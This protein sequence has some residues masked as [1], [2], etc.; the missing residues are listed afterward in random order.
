MD[1]YYAVWPVQT[2]QSYH[3][4]AY[5]VVDSFDF[6]DTGYQTPCSSTFVYVQKSSNNPIQTHTDSALT[7]TMKCI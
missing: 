1:A 6:S 3:I 5:S 2:E 7:S 4:C